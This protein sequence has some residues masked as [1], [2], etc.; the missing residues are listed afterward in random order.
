MENQYGKKELKQECLKLMETADTAYLSIVDTHMILF[1]DLSIIRVDFA[2]FLFYIVL[3]DIKLYF[4]KK[5]K[6]Q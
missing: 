5:G 3:F 2:L 6:K 4:L 1:F